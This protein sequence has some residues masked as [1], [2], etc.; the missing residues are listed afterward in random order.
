MTTK[1]ISITRKLASTYLTIIVAAFI[2]ALFCLTTLIRYKKADHEMVFLNLP[3]I[4]TLKETKEVSE[5]INMLTK[6]WVFLSNQTD[7]DNLNRILS[8]EFPRKTKKLHELALKCDSK[9]DLATFSTIE[10]NNKIAISNIKKIT[11]LLSSFDAYFDENIVNQSVKIYTS[12]IENIL[13]EN[14]KIYTSL[15]EGKLKRQNLIYLEKERLISL[16]ILIV[17]IAVVSILIISFSAIYYTK[18]RI[19]NPLIYLYNLIS[20]VSLGNVQPISKNTNKDEIADM[21]NALS[22][23]IESLND[24]INFANLIGRGNYS[25]HINLLSEKDSL[26]NSLLSMS[27]NL[28]EKEDKLLVSQESLKNAQEISKIGSWEYNFIT[29]DFFWSDELYSI[30]ELNKK[31]T[32]EEIIN[33]YKPKIHPEDK[34]HLRNIIDNT[35]VKDDTFEYEHRIIKNDGTIKYVFGKGVVFKNEQNKFQRVQGIVQD[36]TERKLIENELNKAKERAENLAKAKDEFMSSMSHEIRTPLN[37]I[38]GFTNILMNDKNLQPAQIKQLEAIKTS[39]DILLVI[40]NDILDIAKIESGKMALEHNPINL[41]ELTQL[42]IDTFAVKINEKNLDI[43]LN[44]DSKLTF[45]LLGDSVRMSQV[46]FN[47]ISNAIKFTPENGKITLGVE[48]ERDELEETYIK[49]YVQDSG[50]GIPKEK[51]TKVFEPFVQTSDDTARKY[52]GTGLGLT[53][54][55]KIIDLMKGEIFVESEVGK[56]TKFTIIVPFLKQ[57]YKPIISQIKEEIKFE[58]IVVPEKVEFEETTNDFELAES[59]KVLLAEDNMINQLLAQTV[60]AQFN[61]EVTTVENGLLA[62][63][64]I[65]TSNFDVVLMDLMMPE[66]D[67]YDASIAIRKLDDST[68]KSIPIIALTAD[69][70]NSV[71]TKCK[72]IGMDDY[73]S[74]PFDSQELKVKIEKLINSKK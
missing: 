28:Q 10:K 35:I 57:G 47:F 52:G 23:M 66:M 5:E 14:K 54:V 64:A 73:M 19:V 55:K 49:M 16:L 34:P 43:Q 44:Y 62:L 6:S 22:V 65:K 9:K 38:L 27:S 8:K 45:H 33:A 72:E 59:F 42:I 71:I 12:S 3:C 63:E 51:L 29:K 30:F 70:T 50:I 15:L 24:K 26:G 25:T 39:G 2:S 67:G 58:D 56:G 60:L 17:I 31:E 4:E 11:H 20:E 1:K 36:I 41:K 18:I 46:F 48:I 7:K 74:K 68:K 40:I 21:Q 13:E 32:I 69:V 37:G 53:I 61:F